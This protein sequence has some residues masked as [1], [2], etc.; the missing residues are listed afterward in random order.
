[1]K[2]QLFIYLFGHTTCGILVPQPGIELMPPA[3][4]VWSLNSWTTREVPENAVKSDL[5]QL[6]GDGISQTIKY[7]ANT[8]MIF[9][10][11]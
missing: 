6:Y 4:E 11:S 3:V 9:A 1:M 7:N 8:W 10:I 5:K 2:V